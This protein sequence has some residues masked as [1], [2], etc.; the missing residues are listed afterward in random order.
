[1][2]LTLSTGGQGGVFTLRGGSFGGR[3]QA[4]VSPS[5]SDAQAFFS[6]V[7]TAGGTLSATEQSAIT[8]LVTSLKSTGIWTAMK[9]I[10]PM[11]GSSAAA[12]AQNLVSSSFT[13]TFSSGWTYANTGV[14]PNGTSAFMNTGLNIAANLLQNNTHIS[15]YL[16]TNLNG[17]IL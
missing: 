3:F 2:A 11:V 12:C 9:A 8:T 14:T 7:T 1:M 6:R 15:V 5:D 17:K 13:G 10:Y 16:R 4:S